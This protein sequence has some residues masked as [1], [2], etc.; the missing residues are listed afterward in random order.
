MNKTSF[1]KWRRKIYELKQN[2]YKFSTLGED[3]YNEIL[4]TI[5]IKLCEQKAKVFIANKKDISLAQKKNLPNAVIDRLTINQ[6][7]FDEMVGSIDTVIS[8]S[9]PVNKVIKQWERDIKGN[10]FIVK[11]IC[12]PL[13]VILIVYESRPNVTIDSAVL[14]I[15]SG[16]C[17]VLRGGSEA[18]NTNKML[19]NIIKT[20]IEEVYNKK[21][22]G[23]IKKD[24][25]LFIEDT[26]YS[27]LYKILKLDKEIDLVIPRGGE[28]MISTIRE[29]STIPV[30]SHGSGIC[31]TYVD[32]DANIEVAL[33]VCLN[34]KVQRPSVCNAMETLLVHK[35]ISDKFLPQMAKLFL[36]HNV[37]IRGCKQ[38]AKLLKQYGIKIKLATEQDWSTEYL[39]YIISVKI[40]NNIEEAI[41]H[42]NYY[43]SHHSDAI[44]SE[45][46]QLQEKF[47]QE[48]D[49]SAIFINS[50]TRLHDGG[51][52]GFG[53]EIGISTSKLH[54]RGTMGL[55]E[56]TTTKYVVIGDGVIRE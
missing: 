28:R 48:V 55:N 19:V 15:K 45:N 17:V 5:K 41:W 31:H 7:R 9:S 32:K 30:L 23:E 46:P 22:T 13:G 43:G 56:L 53:T 51:V 50:S 49:S 3:V 18:V 14:C 47:Q 8:L 38:T 21:I 33:K 35:D 29:V 39:D 1:I 10:K 44:I 34:A 26:S 6:K 20:S 24:I 4:K 52:F 37:E 54:A 12:V 2:W 40:V 11:K 27:L 25:V 36:Q 42:I 16:N